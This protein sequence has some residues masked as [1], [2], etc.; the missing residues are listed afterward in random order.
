MTGPGGLFQQLLGLQKQ[1]MIHHA[2]LLPI[3]YL[4]VFFA[5]AHLQN[6]PIHNL[7]LH[8]PAAPA[9]LL[10]IV[11]VLQNLLNGGISPV[12]A[13]GRLFA[14]AVQ[15]EADGIGIHPFSDK[16]VKNEP[17]NVSFFIFLQSG[18]FPLA[19]LYPAFIHAI[20]SHRSDIISL[21]DGELA[22]AV[23][24][25]LGVLQKLISPLQLSLEKIPVIIVFQV[26]DFVRGD[27]LG[28]GETQNFHQP[29]GVFQV[30]AG[31]TLDFHHKDRFNVRRLDE[32][33]QLQKFRPV[34]DGLSGYDF[35]ENILFRN[36]SGK[37]PL[38][39]FLQ[40]CLML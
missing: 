20:G 24:D 32:P 23:Q 11:Y 40:N 38:G 36:R 25:F 35:P 10:V 14:D 16:F 8:G 18:T 5:R 28:V 33:Q 22:A 15:V 12:L 6:F 17:H 30:A 9:D 27:H 31:E 26:I 7:M 4:K 37:V 39:P 13:P 1:L 2:G 3:E 19:F 29:A 34:F 21:A